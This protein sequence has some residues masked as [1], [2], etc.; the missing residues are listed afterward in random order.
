MNE[1]DILIT[2][3]CSKIQISA[4]ICTVEVGFDKKS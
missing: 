3:N 1:T 2:L 4:A